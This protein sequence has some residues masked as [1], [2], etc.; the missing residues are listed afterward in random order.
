MLL[1]IRC[2]YNRSGYRSYLNTSYV[3]VYLFLNAAIPT[4]Q[5]FKYI[6]CYCLSYTA[7]TVPSRIQAFKY[8]LCYC[9]SGFTSIMN[10][11]IP[12]FKYIL[13]YCLSSLY[14]IVPRKSLNLNTSYVI[15]YPLISSHFYM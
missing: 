4:V 1:F 9:L 14:S 3:I 13:C 6:L 7:F 8:I 2:V 15:V 5:E 10:A 11:Q 12:L